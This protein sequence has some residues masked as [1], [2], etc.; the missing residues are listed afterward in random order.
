[1]QDDRPT[2]QCAPGE[3]AQRVRRVIDGMRGPRGTGEELRAIVTVLEEARAAGLGRDPAA[4]TAIEAGTADV[5]PVL[6][7]SALAL[8]TGD[9]THYAG[10][11]GMVGNVLDL[12]PLDG[13]NQIYWSMQ[14]QIFLGRIDP[15][16]VGGFCREDLFAFYR[17]FVAEVG[18][19]FSVNPVPWRGTHRTVRTAAL[20]TNQFLSPQHQP[21]RDLLKQAMQLQARGVE[22]LIV[23]TN[24]MPDRYHSPFV[25]P[26][27]AEIEA[28]LDGRQI[29]SYGGREFPIISSA[30]PGLTAAKVNGFIGA[31]DQADP[32]IVIA[33]G[34]SVLVADLLAAARPGLCL[35]TTTGYTVS[36]AP[37]ILDFG[38]STPPGGNDHYARAWRPFRLGLSLRR[39]P[40]PLTRADYDIGE[41]AFLAVVIGNRLDQE[42]DDAFLRLIGRLLAAEPRMEVAFAGTVEALPRRLA[43]Q[44]GAGRLR[45]L[46]HVDRINGLLAVSDVYLNPRRTG[47]GA[48][49]MQALEEG[50]PVVTFATGDVASVAGDAHCVADADAYVTRTLALAADGGERERARALARNRYRALVEEGGDGEAL[51]SYVDEA[52]GLFLSGIGRS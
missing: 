18:R 47:G 24:M 3:T 28:S 51:L 15:E 25:P 38:G 45:C 42:V 48:S 1:M 46:G 52:Q 30:A 8:L 22:V 35:Q 39:N 21:S 13:I 36:L 4:L 27:A 33:V 19:R 12:A 7:A 23:N 17:S 29:L 26:F 31:I 50:V 10:L 44:A 37:L 32:D 34:G 49:A 9:P 41:G 14:R 5:D 43:A 11:L 40:E 2:I 16:R 20:V 6:R